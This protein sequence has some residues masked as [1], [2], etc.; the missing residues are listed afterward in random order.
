MRGGAILTRIS[1][2]L[3]ALSNYRT[4]KK[5]TMREM[6]D[7]MGLKTPGGYARIESGEVKLKAEHLPIIATQLELTVDQLVHLL[8]YNGV[9]ETSNKSTA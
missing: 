3:N 7:A 8:F 9:D 2:N 5:I 6:A 4:K 1:I